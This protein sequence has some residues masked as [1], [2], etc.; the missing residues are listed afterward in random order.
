MNTLEFIYAREWRLAR[1]TTWVGAMAWILLIVAT[2]GLVLVCALLVVF[3]RCL[4]RSL[5]LAHVRGNAMEI[6]TAQQP[7]LLEQVAA[8]SMTLQVKTPRT[9]L[10]HG[11]QRLY[12]HLLQSLC[13]D[14]LFLL[15]AHVEAARACG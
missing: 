8:C 5:M 15:S 4:M 6:G 10:L 12:S 9:Y 13:K 2:G 11:D 3:M 7:D 1:L 14:H